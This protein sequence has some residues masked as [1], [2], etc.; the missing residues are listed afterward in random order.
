MM[1]MICADIL[2]D[3]NHPRIRLW[4]ISVPPHVIHE[5]ISAKYLWKYGMVSMPL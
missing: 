2:I 4:R 1:M 3:H 5:L